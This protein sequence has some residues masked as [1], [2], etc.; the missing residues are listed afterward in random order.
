M[1][2]RAP[3]G[4]LLLEAMIG[5]ALFVTAVGGLAGALIAASKQIGLASYDAQSLMIARGEVEALLGEPLSSAHWAV[6]TTGP[7]AVAG[8]PGFTL[9]TTITSVTEV[10]GP[11][12][13]TYR[14]AQVTVT[15][16]A[17]RSAAL[18]ARR[19]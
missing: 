16:P 19:W 9:T 17:G 7:A 8:A 11:V 6:G 13:L 3:L 10:A 18:Q 5:G 2:K 14:Q 1:K 12:S 15:A 4:H